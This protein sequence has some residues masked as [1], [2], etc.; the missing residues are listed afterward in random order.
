MSPKEVFET[1]DVLTYKKKANFVISP[2]WLT[3]AGKRYQYCLITCKVQI[4]P[5]LWPFGLIFAPIGASSL[6]LLFAAAAVRGWCPTISPYSLLIKLVKLRF[7]QKFNFIHIFFLCFTILSFV[8]VFWCH[9]CCP[10]VLL[11][12]FWPKSCKIST[13]TPN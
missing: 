3:L 5:V 2:D 7:L 12:S 8:W 11:L 13:V 1:N 4:A 9:K 10:T 6:F